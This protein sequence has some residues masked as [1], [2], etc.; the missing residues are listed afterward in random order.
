MNA[1]QAFDYCWEI[2]DVSLSVCFRLHRIFAETY[3]QWRIQGSRIGALYGCMV[4][5]ITQ[6]SRRFCHHL[7]AVIELSLLQTGHSLTGPQ[8]CRRSRPFLRQPNT[9]PS[10]LLQNYVMFSGSR[11]RHIVSAS[12]LRQVA[13]KTSL[14]LAGMPDIKRTEY[15]QK[16]LA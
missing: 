9:D 11:E 6:S 14:F 10:G 5:M 1:A 12:K 4:G 3:Y 7:M 2:T 15:V 16:W 13:V 8:H